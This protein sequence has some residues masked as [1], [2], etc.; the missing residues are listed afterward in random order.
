MFHGS[1]LVVRIIAVPIVVF[2]KNKSVVVGASNAILVMAA[3]CMICLQDKLFE[4]LLV[5][6]LFYG[7]GW[8]DMCD[9]LTNLN[10]QIMIC[11][12][13]AV[14]ILKYHY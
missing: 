11:H 14:D 5:I 10:Q 6:L 2:Y 7:I 9:F 4:G 3:L 8:S 1:V 13:L 12:H